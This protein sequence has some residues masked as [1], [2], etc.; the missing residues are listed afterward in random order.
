MTTTVPAPVPLE[1]PPGDVEALDELAQEV[2]AAAFRLAGLGDRLAGPAAAAPGWVGDDATAA[3]TQMATV[4]GLAR[5]CSA[6]VLSAAGR[7][8]AHAE[9]LQEARRGVGRLRA[10]QDEDFR[11][12][13]A[14]LGSLRFSELMVMADAPE[15][16]AIVAEFEAAEAARRRRHAVLLAEVADDAAATSRALAQYCGVVGGRGARGDADRV[17]AH[18]AAALPGWGDAELTARGRALALALVTG[19]LTP[20][21]REARAEGVADF[22]GMQAFAD[23]FL[24]GLGADGVAGLLGFL[25]YNALTST[26]AVARLLASAFAAAGPGG[27]PGDPLGEV[28]AAVYVRADDGYGASDVVAAGMAAVL[29]A[30]AS[31]GRT[32]RPDVL[33]EWG[34]QMLARERAQGLPAG[35]G[36]MDPLALV[37]QGLADVGGS[38]PAL[39]LLGAP[40]AWD[41]LLARFW[42]DGAVALGNLIDVAASGPGEDGA[43]VVRSGL[44]ALGAGLADGDPVDWTVSPL[45]AAAVAPALGRAVAAHV[46]VAADA[47]GVGVD[48]RMTAVRGRVLRG[49][50]YLTLD[51]GAAAAVESALSSWA[52]VRP[53][54]LDGTSPLHPLP[55]VAV[56]SAY[57]AVEEYGQR[58]SYAMHGFDERRAAEGKQ[59]LWDGTIGLAVGLVPGRGGIVGG[60]LEGY[61]AIALGTDGTWDNGPDRGMVFDRS[62]AAGAA[63]TNLPPESAVAAG[64]V[65]RQAAAA[66]DRTL[67]ALQVPEPPT[68]PESDWLAPIQDAMGPLRRD[69]ADARGLIPVR[70]R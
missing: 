65:A 11:A 46:E 44:E 29:A 22:S 51:R 2:R 56:P 9:R 34:R 52:R 13:R 27:G 55:A 59:A 41:T 54:T 58:L 38:G 18:L 20:E 49:L 14:G 40:R 7:L 16:V 68:S 6:A 1:M 33:V 12:A 15:A 66:F 64:A 36:A 45:T 37:A 21:Q 63:L 5:D 39:A 19:S 30:S 24:V 26:S 53:G 61:A 50:G 60:V 42:T 32:L 35:G 10:E 28:V 25:G 69:L 57:L 67:R 31:I 3:V 70:H 17:V 4:A 48:G 47:L 23:A 8:S 62:K 43:A